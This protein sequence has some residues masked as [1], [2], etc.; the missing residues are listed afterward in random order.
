M[1]QTVLP[2]M[3]GSTILCVSMDLHW[4]CVFWGVSQ[5]MTVESAVRDY[6]GNECRV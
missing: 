6:S 2:S 1:A 3:D 5:H 4:L